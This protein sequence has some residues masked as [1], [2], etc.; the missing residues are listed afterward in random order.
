MSNDDKVAIV[1]CEKAA[2]T[3]GFEQAILLCIGNDGRIVASSWGANR[4]KCE[5]M[6]IALN[7]IMDLLENDK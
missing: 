6:G 1:A 7:H 4:R 5:A 3:L 2:M